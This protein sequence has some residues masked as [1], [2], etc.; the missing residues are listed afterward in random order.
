MK[1]ERLQQVSPIFHQV[2]GLPP[3][4]RAAF[5]ASACKGDA[6]LREDVESLLSAHERAG[7]FIESPAYERAAE[8]LTDE[9]ASL[10]GQLIAH[11]RIV[12]PLGRGGMGEV[13]LARDTKLERSVALKFLPS[14]VASDK[15][16]MR[17]F[18]QEA[19]AAAALNHPNIAHIY[20]IG[21]TAATH[22]IAM[23]Y[24]DGV[25]LSEKIHRVKTPLG[26]LLKYLTQVAEGLAKAHAAGIVHRDLKPDNI[27]ITRDDYAKIL[28]FGLAKLVEPQRASGE[29]R[30]LPVR[31]PRL[32][33]PSTRCPA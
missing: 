6:T 29:E 3:E 17:R 33:W 21:E 11:Y 5:L 25:T 7:S 24:V 1:A 13:Y 20:E 2:V 19:K 4:E 31:P 15:E 32:S 27:M 18:T 14:N 30:P 28:D 12:A 10:V 26:K 8:L 16:K 9:P 23:E 22:F